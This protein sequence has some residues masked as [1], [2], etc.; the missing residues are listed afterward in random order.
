[1]VFHNRSWLSSGYSETKFDADFNV[2]RYL[3]IDNMVEKSCHTV[4]IPTFNR[5]QQLKRLLSYFN[6]IGLKSNIL[7]LDSSDEE[8]KEQIQLLIN[9]GFIRV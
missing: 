2:K 9:D 8:N 7:I 1:M 6:K 5:P 3:Q 4:V